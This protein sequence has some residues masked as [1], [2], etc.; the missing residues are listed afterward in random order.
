MRRGLLLLRGQLGG[1]ALRAELRRARHER[2]ARLRVR[3]QLGGGALRV[4]L[5]RP[6]RERRHQLHMRQRLYR[7]RRR[8]LRLQF[9]RVRRR[10]MRR[11]PVSSIRAGRWLRRVRA[12]SWQRQQRRSL[13][14]DGAGARA[15]GERRDIP[16]WWWHFM[17]RRVRNDA[18]RRHVVA[19]LHV[20]RSST[21]DDVPVKLHESL[22]LYGTTLRTPSIHSNRP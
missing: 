7:L 5:R 17:L 10:V 12:P 19:D 22:D 1:R 8:G 21:E 2:W 16:R 13:C 18:R 14:R 4:Q 11:A 3:G 15:D 20:L 6:R 9:R